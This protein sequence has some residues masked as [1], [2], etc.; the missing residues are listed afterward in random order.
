MSFCFSYSSIPRDLDLHERVAESLG[1]E[2]FS[3]GAAWW[4]RTLLTQSL[5]L[6]R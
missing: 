6:N 1:A 2:V 3:M 4:A 5:R